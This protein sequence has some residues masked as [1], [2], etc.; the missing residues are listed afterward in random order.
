MD[1]APTLSNA[2]KVRFSYVAGEIWVRDNYVLVKDEHIP[3]AEVAH[4]A[5]ARVDETLKKAGSVNILFDTRDMPVPSEEVNAIYWEWVTAGA[6]HKHVA[7]LVNSEMKRIEGNMR[8]VSKGVRLRS[9]HSLED[10]EAWFN[11]LSPRR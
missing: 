11:L 9:F 5:L 2:A 10:A 1:T 8:A 3:D 7:L 4:K 6:N